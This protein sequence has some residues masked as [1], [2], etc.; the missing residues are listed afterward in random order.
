MWTSNSL[1]RSRQLNERG[2]DCHDTTFLKVSLLL[3][4]SPGGWLQPSSTTVYDCND[5]YDLMIP[6]K[7]TNSRFSSFWYRSYYDRVLSC[8]KQL[9]TVVNGR[10]SEFSVVSAR[11]YTVVIRSILKRRNTGFLRPC[12]NVHDYL[13]PSFFN[14]HL[15]D[16]RKEAHN[17]R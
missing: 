2:V 14:L 4:S 17:P 6:F 15:Y 16:V 11:Q 3:F 13:R 5:V 7:A 8:R 1:E 9:Y 12:Y 10:K